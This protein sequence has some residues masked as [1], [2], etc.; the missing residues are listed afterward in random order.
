MPAGSADP[1]PSVSV[2]P[3]EQRQGTVPHRPNS[4][5]MSASVRRSNAASGI[6][7]FRRS[8]GGAWHPRGPPGAPGMRTP[9][10]SREVS[11]HLLDAPLARGVPEAGPGLG[12]AGEQ[13][14]GRVTLGGERCPARRHSRGQGRLPVRPWKV[15]R[16]GGD[17][18]PRR[19]RTGL[20]LPG[21]PG[22]P[23]GYHAPRQ[24]R[25]KRLDA[26]GGVRPPDACRHRR[27]IPVRCGTAPWRCSMGSTL[28]RGRGSAPPAGT[29]SPP[30]RWA[31]IISGHEA[32]HLRVL[33]E[34]YLPHL[35]S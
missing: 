4:A 32:H 3:M 27:R 25:R 8:W 9:V 18:T 5:A 14:G 24:L 21:A 23:R 15:E 33:A 17:R 26:G 31:W 16:Q 12:N 19:L 1:R 29:R 20:L 35:G 2:E 30:G 13:G 28:T 22:G 34:R 6:Q 7:A 10:R 11:D